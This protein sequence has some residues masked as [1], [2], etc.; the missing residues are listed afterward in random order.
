MLGVILTLLV[1]G[2]LTWIGV[3]LLERPESWE[4]PE[5]ATSRS[6]NLVDPTHLALP[7]RFRCASCASEVG[8]RADPPGPG[9]LGSG[10]A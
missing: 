4:L 9:T 8:H 1:G 2:I 3:R 5:R 6:P 7:E 10:A